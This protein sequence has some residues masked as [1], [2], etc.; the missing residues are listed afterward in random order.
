MELKTSVEL[1][2]ILAAKYRDKQRVKKI[3]EYYGPEKYL[4]HMMS[5][6]LP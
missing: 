1:I 6:Y 3:L 4:K 2:K 5:L